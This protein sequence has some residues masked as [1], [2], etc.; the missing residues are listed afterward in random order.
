[1]HKE[2]DTKPVPGFP[3]GF[4]PTSK[5][6]ISLPGMPE[7]RHE[8]AASE[9]DLTADSDPADLAR[10]LSALIYGMA[11][12]ASGGANRR[13]LQGVADVALRHWPKPTSRA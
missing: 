6:G 1:M 12:L 4:I 9:G 10:Y 8:R 3:A 2:Q 13:E 5:Q 7:G 11:V